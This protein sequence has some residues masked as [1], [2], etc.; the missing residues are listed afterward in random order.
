MSAV[1]LNPSLAPW[2]SSPEPMRDSGRQP[3]GAF[4]FS[5][6]LKGIDQGSGT[7]VPAQNAGAAIQTRTG[8]PSTTNPGIAMPTAAAA[9]PASLDIASSS[10]APTSNP[11]SI[12]ADLAALGYGPSEASQGAPSQSP[13][14]QASPSQGAAAQT[15]AAPVSPKSQAPLSSRAN[16][17]LAAP[18]PAPANSSDTTGQN[19]AVG[20]PAA[21]SD[22]PIGAALSSL[23]S[24]NSPN[25]AALPSLGSDS[26]IVAAL[27]SLGSDSP[28]GAALPSLVSDSP[29]VAALPSLVSGASPNGAAL[30]S[31]GSGASPDVG[32][33]AIS[34][35]WGAS[36]PAQIRAAVPQRQVATTWRAT[37]T[38]SALSPVAASQ[39][40]AA[41]VQT[42]TSGGLQSAVS[43]SA[44]TRPD[45]AAQG[46]PAS[47]LPGQ[48][49]VVPQGA[50]FQAP[51]LQASTPQAAALPE[52]VSQAPVLASGISVPAPSGT[53]PSVPTSSG[54]AAPQNSFGAA[55][56]TD[57]NLA[58]LSSASD[59]G[60]PLA[61]NVGDAAS[62][63][64][65]VNPLTADPSL[66][67]Q[68]LQSRTHLAMT[69][70]LP[71]RASA[72][73]ATAAASAPVG[74]SAAATQ[75]SSEP[76]VQQGDAAPAQQ[77]AAPAPIS[78]IDADASASTPSS[79]AAVAVAGP[80]IDP[81]SSGL[82]SIPLS[83]LADFVADQASSLTS[84]GSPSAPSSN[85]AA[86]QA[87]KE[88]EISLD[89]ANLG[90]VSVKMRL[91][92]G[93][94]SIVI[95][96]SNSSTLAAIENERGAIAAR[97]GSTEQPL[98]NLAIV[99]R[100]P[101]NE[102]SQDFAQT[103]SGGNDASDQGSQGYTRS[104]DNFSGAQRG[105]NGS[106]RSRNEPSAGSGS[107]ATTS[108]R[109][110]GDLLV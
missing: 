34:P 14:S 58:G 104:N 92:N 73:R 97:L 65:I 5:S 12:E 42:Q 101:S 72:P 93:K 62:Y 20:D 63:A 103:N 89:P 9:S 35:G 30:S 106:P 70:A 6:I 84:P 98:E 109:G 61:A 108:G 3:S 83:Q 59:A 85:A 16:P 80:A 11:P 22:P 95:G 27:P 4:S 53:A 31:L 37:T 2:Q 18:T 107:T 36:A 88:L 39:G 87:V 32:S 50:A 74:A 67:L 48:A 7:S 1:A 28:N 110:A 23:G 105:E 54:T 69:N 79:V 40:A 46:A 29:I 94:L 56:R 57:P 71:V 41:S 86:P 78:P 47:S 102:T 49:V 66:G 43:S 99:S 26:P 51:A 45:P 91:A 68:S 82:A 96:V 21:T 64:A 60:S 8:W 13:V 17:G 25:G 44:R 33:S 77:H 38:P 76:T 55:P 19:D 15:P 90:A 81:S 24:G 52:S 100:E 10:P 75:T